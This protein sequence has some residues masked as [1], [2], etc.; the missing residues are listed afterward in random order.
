MR[1]PPLL[2]LTRQTSINDLVRWTLFTAVALF[3]FWRA[4]ETTLLWMDD[5]IGQY[6]EGILLTN[7]NA[8]SWGRVPYRDFYSNYPPGIFL[9]LAGLFALFGPSLLVERVLGVFLH[10]AVAAGAGRVTA[11]MLGSRF[12]WMPAALVMLWFI[13]LRAVSFAWLAGFA[14]ALFSIDL[15]VAAHARANRSLYLAAGGLLGTVS[16]FRHDLFVYFALWLG[17]AAAAWAGW[18]YRRERDREPL[19]AILWTG[20]GT[21]VAL[22]LMWLPVFALAGIRQTTADLYFTQVRHVMPARELP[23]PGPFP[24][25]EASLPLPLPQATLP[26]PLPAFLRADFEGGVAYTLIAPVLA[27]AA[28]LAPRAVG[29]K[30]RATVVLLGALSA[31]VM[32]QMLGRT[33]HYH[34]I[35]AVPPALALGWLWAFG[36]SGSRLDA[37]LGWLRAL[38]GLWLLTQ[39]VGGH[40]AELP[41]P[42]GPTPM[43]KLARLSGRWTFP[44]R[45]Q[46]LAFIAKRTRPGDPLFVGQLDHRWTYISET[47]L[48]FLANRVGATRYTQFDPNVTNRE[49]V[50][51][52]M[53][54]Q[55]EQ[56]RPRVVVLATSYGGP[57]EEPNESRNEGSGALDKYL[58]RRYRTVRTV[59]GY[60]LLV[61]KPRGPAERQR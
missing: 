4:L 12:E 26:F 14:M 6:D 54:S 10:L 37:G 47:D 9:V 8:L 48:Y 15:W 22:V 51:R 30:S 11:R 29:L 42:L 34:A 24:L 41:K 3:L 18:S 61:R 1:F 46:V 23:L 49:D 38:L 43:P 19:R 58:H 53:I 2:R 21:A 50:Q 32:P 20:A 28:L 44:G 7:A 56:V 33:D 45:R 5:A 52:E 57:T 31:A 13:P 60:A 17:G 36:R 59:E 27:I 40:L 35:F 39:P 55:L 25:G 16:W